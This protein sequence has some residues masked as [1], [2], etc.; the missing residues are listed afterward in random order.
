LVFAACISS[1]VDTVVVGLFAVVVRDSIDNAGTDAVSSDSVGVFV[2]D[3]VG[4]VGGCFDIATNAVEADT[5]GVVCIFD[6]VEES[7]VDVCADAVDVDIVEFVC[8]VDIVERSD[9]G[10][11]NGAIVDTVVGL[12]VVVVV[13]V[14][15]GS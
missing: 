6:V 11:G 9:F 13:K 7:N 14:F 8:V 4:A 2:V 10:G 3:L 12:K 5:V 15:V 1:V